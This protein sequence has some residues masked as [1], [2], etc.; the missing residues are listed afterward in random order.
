M[1]FFM[2]TNIRQTVS[3]LNFLPYRIVAM[4]HLKHQPDRDYSEQTSQEKY[5]EVYIR[6]QTVSLIHKRHLAL[7]SSR[8]HII[9]YNIVYV[10]YIHEINKATQLI[11]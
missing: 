8:E 2:Y 1:V 10:R 7:N 5:P 11:C 6:T 9:C 3:L 4:N